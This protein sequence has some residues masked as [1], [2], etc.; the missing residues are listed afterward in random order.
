MNDATPN[1]DAERNCPQ[2]GNRADAG[3]IF[4]AKCGAAI[5]PPFPLTQST[6]DVS[7]PPAPSPT[8]R[9]VVAVLKG[10]RG[11]AVVVFI[12][13]P[14]RSRALVLTFIGS[15][16]VF[17]ICHWLLTTLDETYI[18]KHIKNGYWPQKPIDWTPSVTTDNQQRVPNDKQ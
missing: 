3:L 6:Q 16:I 12:L 18:D 1:I 17:L 13:C 9:L 10:I 7:G 5:Q 4:C 15:V 11:I 8:K 14:F 2:C